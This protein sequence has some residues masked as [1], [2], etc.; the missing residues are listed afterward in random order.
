MQVALNSDDELDT[1]Y[2][3][4]KALT[5]AAVAGVLVVALPA[6]G[7]LALTIGISTGVAYVSSAALIFFFSAFEEEFAGYITNRRHNFSD[8]PIAKIFQG[9][10]KAENIKGTNFDDF[11]YGLGGSD[12]IRGNHG[13]DHLYGGMGK[14]RLFGGAGADSLFGGGTTKADILMGG[15]ENDTLDG[16]RGYDKLYG[17][18]GDDWFVWRDKKASL[19]GGDGTD[20]VTSEITTIDF[21][22]FRKRFDSVENI[23]LSGTETAELKARNAVGDFNDNTILGNGNNKSLDGYQGDEILA[24][25]AGDDELFGRA[26]EDSLYGG[27]DNDTLTGG[28]G[29]DSLWGHDGDDTFVFDRVD[30]DHAFGGYGY[31]DDTFIFKT[32]ANGTVIFDEFG[33]DTLDLTQI[34]VSKFDF[35][36]LGTEIEG[37]DRVIVDDLSS[38]VRGNLHAQT[39]VLKKD[40]EIALTI[41]IDDEDAFHNLGFRQIELLDGAK[42]TVRLNF[43]DPFAQPYFNRWSAPEV[44]FD[45]SIPGNSSNTQSSRIEL[46]SLSFTAY[47]YQMQQTGGSAGLVCNLDVFATVYGTAPSFLPSDKLDSYLSQIFGEQ[48]SIYFTVYELYAQDGVQLRAPTRQ[49]DMRWDTTGDLVDV[50]LQH[51]AWVLTFA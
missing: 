2:I 23:D 16:G 39:L 29:D 46:T 21:N 20:W 3:A 15:S 13:A 19:F 12:V 34:N 45:I 42:L 41:G 40:A 24:G 43:A 25:R 28:G 50:E 8:D 35:S 11:L 17:E 27:D 4:L 33:T 47:S 26:G 9:G 36:R 49:F 10:E 22:V 51:D 6:T 31:G 1:R 5:A 7:T 18:D 48:E 44:P 38:N 30:A 37:I 32:L 14:D